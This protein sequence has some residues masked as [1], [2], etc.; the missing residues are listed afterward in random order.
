MKVVCAREALVKGLARVV[1]AAATKNTMPILSHV[2]L[3]AKE[4]TLHLLATDL[5]VGMEC[6]IEGEIADRGGVAVPARKLYDIVKELSDDSVHLSLDQSGR[7]GIKCGSFSCRIVALPEE[8]FPSLPTVEDAGKIE[9]D[10]ALFHAMVTRTS[11]SVSQDETRVTLTGI[12][13]KAEK[14]KS[15]FEM[16]ATDSHRLALAKH[17]LAKPAEVSLG[18]IVPRK[19]L[20]E[21]ARL[22]E[23]LEEAISIVPGATHVKF[24]VGP[25]TVLARLIEGKFPDYYQV[26]PKQ[27]S[28][29]IK[30]S[31]EKFLAAT[32][33]IQHMAVD[34][35]NSIK[36]ELGPDKMTLRASTSD[37]GEADEELSANVQGEALTVA[38]NSRYV[39][40]VLR[41]LKG[42]EIDFGITD[43]IGP[44]ILTSEADPAYVYVVMPMRI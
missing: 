20:D 6:E 42:E 19:A 32:K 44:S 25:V 17:K 10:A 21:V 9:M 43:A 26:I 22:S 31:R 23:G 14:G 1:P 30:I 5:Q 3:K 38:Y 29:K 7:L 11:F 12:Y 8:D 18:A 33:R 16:V 24:E 27:T 39:L 41:V 2:L 34:R 13:L 35:S 4:K 36:H 28:R 15:E 40:D 37:V